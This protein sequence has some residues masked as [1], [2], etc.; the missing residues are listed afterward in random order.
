MYHGKEW[1]NAE[2]MPSSSGELRDREREQR[3]GAGIRDQVQ[4]NCRDLRQ[5]REKLL[6]S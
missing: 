5:D 6:P 4:R 1:V 3:G 2:I